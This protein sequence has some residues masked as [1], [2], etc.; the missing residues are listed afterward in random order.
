MTMMMMMM[1]RKEDKVKE[2][3]TLPHSASIVPAASP[4]SPAHSL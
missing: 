1:Q 3:K 2:W 4:A